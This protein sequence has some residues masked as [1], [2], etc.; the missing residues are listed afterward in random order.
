[1]ESQLWAVRARAQEA[2]HVARSQP[3]SHSQGCRQW[4][5]SEAVFAFQP[6]SQEDGSSPLAKHM[7]AHLHSHALTPT[8]THI[9]PHTETYPQLVYTLHNHTYTHS[10]MW[11]SW[12]KREKR[13][14]TAVSW[15][16]PHPCTWGPQVLP[17]AFSIRQSP[18]LTRSVRLWAS[19]P[20]LPSL[21]QQK[22]PWQPL[23]TFLLT[24]FLFPSRWETPS[25][26][27]PRVFH[28]SGLSRIWISKAVPEG[29]RHTQRLQSCPQRQVWLPPAHL[30]SVQ[31]GVGP[32]AC[33]DAESTRSLGSGISK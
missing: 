22:S 11:L 21:C 12:L 13:K 24:P 23:L 2:W 18:V 15:F 14:H 1:M 9:C 26:T 5:I 29:R 33:P 20:G 10:H 31:I 25:T 28:L 32:L 16:S 4:L 17:G 3:E 27:R 30:L 19:W 7:R 6:H 8:H